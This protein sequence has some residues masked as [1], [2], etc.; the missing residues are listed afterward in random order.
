MKLLDLTRDEKESCLVQAAF[1]VEGIRMGLWWPGRG[2]PPTVFFGFGSGLVRHGF[3]WGARARWGRG[4]VIDGWTIED[5]FP[6]DLKRRK[7]PIYEKA[8]RLGARVVKIVTQHEYMTPGKKAAAEIER[9]VDAV[10]YAF[11]EIETRQSA[12]DARFP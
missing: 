7:S 3:G 1:E 2:L 8:G 5:E 12:S 4:Q 11:S 6:E 9:S 10:I